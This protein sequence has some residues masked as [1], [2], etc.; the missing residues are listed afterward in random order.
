MLVIYWIWNRFNRIL[1]Q[2]RQPVS[3]LFLSNHCWTQR[4]PIVCVQK[5]QITLNRKSFLLVMCKALHTKWL[6]LNILTFFS[7]RNSS[8]SSKDY[9]RAYIEP[10]NLRFS[11]ASENLLLCYNFFI[12]ANQSLESIIHLI[13]YKYVI[14]T[15]NYIV[16]VNR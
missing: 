3:L 15:F 2:V 16:L 13:V 4:L 8:Y 14:I 1:I 9:W 11:N 10:V 5:H 12:H 7:K 6:S